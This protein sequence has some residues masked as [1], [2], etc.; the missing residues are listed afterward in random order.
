MKGEASA[1]KILGEKLR[2][3]KRYS[4]RYSNDAFLLVVATAHK[5]D[6][7]E[8]MSAIDIAD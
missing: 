5:R 7:A 4:E 3:D 1:L 8:Y 6:V 2:L